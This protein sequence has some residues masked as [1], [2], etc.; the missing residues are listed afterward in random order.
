MHI[1]LRKAYTHLGKLEHSERRFTGVEEFG[2]SLIFFRWANNSSSKVEDKLQ[3]GLEITQV[4]DKVF[5][6]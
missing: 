6:L 1:Q 4:K 5:I 2:L 3:N